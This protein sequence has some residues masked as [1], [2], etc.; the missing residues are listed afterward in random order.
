MRGRRDG[1]HCLRLPSHHTREFL[2][3]ILIGESPQKNFFAPSALHLPRAMI[4]PQT[5]P[6]L[7]H[8]K[9]FQA[10]FLEGTNDAP[11]AW[12]GILFASCDLKGKSSCASPFAR[13]F[14]PPPLRGQRQL[15]R[16]P[17]PRTDF[18]CRD[19]NGV[20]RA[21]APLPPTASA[22][23][24]LPAQTP[25]AASIL[26]TLTTISADTG[27]D[28]IVPTDVPHDLSA[29]DRTPAASSLAG[30]TRRARKKA[31]SRSTRAPAFFL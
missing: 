28:T 30:C 27:A 21:T 6:M 1:P 29:G 13:W 5:S 20:I 31:W 9:I 18:A 15:P 7:R 8:F 16:R 26:A 2:L 22:W 23:R 17:P 11:A 25:G 24:Q 12:H 4:E 3:C 14:W 19:G 10:I